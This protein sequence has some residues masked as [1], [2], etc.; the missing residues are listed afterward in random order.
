MPTPDKGAHMSKN[1]RRKDEV[2][3]PGPIAKHPVTGGTPPA[4]GETVTDETADRDDEEKPGIQP[5][6]IR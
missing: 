5:E 4:P 1:E 2:V 3:E 6:D